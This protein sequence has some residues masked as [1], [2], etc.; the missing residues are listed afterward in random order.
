MWRYDRI[1]VGPSA[2][3]LEHLVSQLLPAVRALP[4]LDAWFFLR[5]IDEEGLHLRLRTRGVDPDTL[6]REVQPVL[7]AALEGLVGCPQPWYRPT[8]ALQ[9]PQG[10]AA[11]RVQLITQRGYEREV[12]RYGR[13]GIRA[14]ERLFQRSSDVAVDTILAE[15]RGEL[16][17]KT[18]VPALMQLTATAFGIEDA[19][20][21]WRSYASH[22]L[23][24]SRVAA[25]CT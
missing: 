25:E 2:G 13:Q 15:R 1:Y 14:A 7:T 17:R 19:A 9:V 20:G 6:D 3:G 11:D 21:F 23:R 16:S 18:L 4:S 5:Y 10:P 12:A 22:W 8:I 24:V